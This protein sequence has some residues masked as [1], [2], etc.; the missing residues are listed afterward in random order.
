MTLL[1]ILW[2]WL[3]SIVEAAAKQSRSNYD[4]IIKH[5]IESKSFQKS[6]AVGSFY[7]S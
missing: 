3:A 4:V 6:P 7:V 2:L 1:E 5:N